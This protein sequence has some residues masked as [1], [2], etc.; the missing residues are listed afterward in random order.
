[1]PSASRG[2]PVLTSSGC[3]ATRCLSELRLLFVSRLH[4]GYCRCTPPSLLSPVAVI[5]V[6]WPPSRCYEAATTAAPLR[7]SPS[8]PEECLFNSG[9]PRRGGGSTMSGL[10]VELLTPHRVL[11]SI[12]VSEVG[13]LCGPHLFVHA[14][15]KNQ[16]VHDAKALSAPAFTSR[17]CAE[18]T[19]LKHGSPGSEGGFAAEW[20]KPRVPPARVFVWLS[21]PGRTNV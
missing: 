13:L 1:M 18:G 5:A 12:G 10:P 20:T 6:F 11:R 14:R 8:L 2:T 9:A 21:K 17:P 15:F 19:V 16:P 3:E 4:L 7:R